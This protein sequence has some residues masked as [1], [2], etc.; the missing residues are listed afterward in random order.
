[1]DDRRVR[2][3]DW[4]VPDRWHGI[5]CWGRDEGRKAYPKAAVDF[6][7][8]L[9]IR[10]GFSDRLDFLFAGGNCA[11]FRHKRAFDVVC[12]SSQIGAQ[13]IASAQGQGTPP[14]KKKKI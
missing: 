7:Y 14:K 6:E 2:N 9:E 1:M 11:M 10:Y 12:I 4:Q 8:W 5:W 13:L 3:S